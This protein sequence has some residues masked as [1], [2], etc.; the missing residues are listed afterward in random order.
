MIPRLSP[1]IAIQE[2]FIS[3]SLGRPVESFESSFAELA[4]TKHAIAFPYGRTALMCLLEALGVQQQ[5]I[6]C[7]SYTCIVVPHAITHSQNVPVFI[8][9]SKNSFLMNIELASK[10]AFDQPNVGAM[11]ST[12]IFGEPVSLDEL[13]DFAKRHPDILI[14]Q[15]CAHSFLCEYQSRAVHKYGVAAI[16]GLNFSKIVTS[17][18]GGMVT[19]DDEGLAKRLREVRSRKLTPGTISKS[20]ARRIYY[21]AALFGLW[22]PLFGGVKLLQK[23]GAIDRFVKY[24]NDDEIDMPSDY[25][26]GLTEFEALIGSRQCELY[27]DVV[28]HRRSIANQY[29]QGLK[30]S[31]GIILPSPVTGHTYSHYTIIVENSEQLIIE[32]SREGIELGNLI[33]YSIPNLSTYK[34]HIFYDNGNSKKFIGKTVNLPV[35]KGVSS[36]TADKIIKTIKKYFSDA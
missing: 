13:D 2:L 24:Y 30:N 27:D 31:Q 26:T 9:S 36:Y 25:L 16:Y 28:S 7:P 22:P 5:Q 21:V 6:L 10:A 4:K 14:I 15:D 32:L 12:P 18:F 11:I 29:Y 34:D 20:I 8:D 1:A 19:T 3:M 23:T 33:E 35:H 17:V